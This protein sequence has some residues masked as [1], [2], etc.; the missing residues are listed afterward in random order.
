MREIE[1][2]TGV[3]RRQLYRLLQRCLKQA[4]D[5]R[6]LGF[7]NLLKH[8]RI[9]SLLPDALHSICSPDLDTAGN[10]CVTAITVL[11]IS[12]SLSGGALSTGNCW[13][14]RVD[15]VVQSRLIGST[16]ICWMRPIDVETAAI[17]TVR[18][19]LSS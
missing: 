1:E 13:R 4:D 14:L 11:Y 2:H 8:H 16:R 10:A 18:P 17:Y 15:I 12:S 5:G 6:I 3:N 7:R 9:G 19:H